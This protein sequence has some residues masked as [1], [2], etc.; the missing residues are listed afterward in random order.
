[1]SPHHHRDGNIAG[2]IPHPPAAADGLGWTL[3]GHLE[4]AN[5]GTFGEFEAGLAVAKFTPN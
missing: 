3:A 4:G 2:V 5:S 1:M